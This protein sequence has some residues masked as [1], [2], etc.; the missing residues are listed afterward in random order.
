MMTWQSFYISQVYI[1]IMH[2]YVQSIRMVGIRAFD[3]IQQTTVDYLYK[4][5]AGTRS[6]CS[7][8][9]M[10]LTSLDTQ[11]SAAQKED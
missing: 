2:C 6:N 3:H 7:I 1:F 9:V 10:L 8:Y 4:K 5:Q 11:H